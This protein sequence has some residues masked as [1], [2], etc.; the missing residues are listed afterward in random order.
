M[1]ER[2]RGIEQ[3]F[4]VGIVYGRRRFINKE[5][6]ITS[7]TEILLI[8]VSRYDANKIGVFKYDLWK[9]FG[10]ESAKYENIWD[11][12][13]YMRL[14]QPALASLHALGAGSEIEPC[15]IL[16]HNDAVEVRN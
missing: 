15:V 14:A 1:S 8:D 16:S 6:N 2:F 10:I 12:E 7:N 9:M 13:Q 5:T 4:G 11:F 3:E